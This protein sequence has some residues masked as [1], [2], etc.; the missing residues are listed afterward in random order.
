[1]SP[2]HERRSPSAS[3]HH[4]RPRRSAKRSLTIP[5][6][7]LS[8]IAWQD[9]AQAQ[10]QLDGNDPLAPSDLG[11]GPF[12]EMSA[13]L[14]VTVFRIDV[15]TLTVRVGPETAAKL[16]STAEGSPYS[17]ELADSVALVMLDAED[18]WAQQLF[19]RDVGFDR[20]LGGMRE[21]VE[22]AAEAGFVSL[23]YSERFSVALPNWFGFLTD[24][25]AKEGD[26]IIFRTRGDTLRMVYRTA[27]GRILLDQN[28]ADAEG[29]RASI[30][31][32]FAPGTR[33]RRR[34]VESLLAPGS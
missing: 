17:E 9:R 11:D 16:R 7:L 32:F 33:F 21:T 8:A 26:Q 29:R 5:L 22:K 28:G 10:Y 13:L 6:A 12:Q 27:D 34:L 15:L 19:H 1:M 18:A 30:P 23:E 3:G 14:E 31:S 20:L 2:V 25:G 4:R 24:S